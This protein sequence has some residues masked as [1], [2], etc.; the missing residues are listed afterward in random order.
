MLK[1]YTCGINPINMNDKH[2]PFCGEECHNEW[3]S[4]NIRP[5]KKSKFERYLERKKRTYANR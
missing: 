3:A 4:K 1:C 2:F 5:K